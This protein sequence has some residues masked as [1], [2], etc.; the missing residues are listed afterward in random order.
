MKG[1]G[2]EVNATIHDP[3]LNGYYGYNYPQYGLSQE[4]NYNYLESP[5]PVNNA[6]YTGRLKFFDQSGNYGL[7]IFHIDLL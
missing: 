6:R 1:N 5:C 7:N 2:Y 4:P 3:S